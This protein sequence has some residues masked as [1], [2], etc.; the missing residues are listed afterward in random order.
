MRFRIHLR[1]GGLKS[2]ENQKRRTKI[3]KTAVLKCIF[4]AVLLLLQGIQ[5]GSSFKRILRRKHVR[6]PKPKRSSWGCHLDASNTDCRNKR[7]T[8]KVRK[9]SIQKVGLLNVSFCNHGTFWTH[10]QKVFT[11]K[12]RAFNQIGVLCKTKVDAICFICLKI[13][14]F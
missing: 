6:Y 5:E 10:G 3:M 11:R 9:T 4:V 2:S 7:D 14:I 1:A 12:L 13:R 8:R